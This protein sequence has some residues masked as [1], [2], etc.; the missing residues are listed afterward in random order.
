MELLTE[1]SNFK[2]K[3]PEKIYKIIKCPLK[4]VLKNFDIIQ[5]IIENVVIDINQFV[6]LGYQFIR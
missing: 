3:P 6:I 1:N 4:A 5:P 2:D